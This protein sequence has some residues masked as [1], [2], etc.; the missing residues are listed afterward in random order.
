LWLIRVLRLFR[1]T[2]MHRINHKARINHNHPPS[3]SGISRIRGISGPARVAMNPP[4]EAWG[5]P[6]P[7][8]RNQGH[9]TPIVRARIRAL[10]HPT[11]GPGRG[12][13]GLVTHRPDR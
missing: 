8:R 4:P 11:P 13:M 12:G 10:W 1:G 2:G 5:A 9:P 7:G 3:I 6:S